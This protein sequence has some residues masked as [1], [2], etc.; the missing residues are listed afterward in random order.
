LIGYQRKDSV[1]RQIGCFIPSKKPWRLLDAGGNCVI[2]FLF[3]MSD[4]TT[5]NCNTLG[6]TQSAGGMKKILEVLLMWGFNF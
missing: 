5:V 3:C 2:I 1:G 6:G 4:D